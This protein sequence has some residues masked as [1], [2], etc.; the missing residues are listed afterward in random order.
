MH[1]FNYDSF[2]TKYENKKTRTFFEYL[3]EYLEG[4]DKS[5]ILENMTEEQIVSSLEHYI[6]TGVKYQI[7][8]NNY[9]SYITRIF[10]DLYKTYG[11]V[12]KLIADKT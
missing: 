12:N 5:Y 7:T 1:N 2:K 9:F 10:D 3:E 4:E 8:A 11:I 6:S